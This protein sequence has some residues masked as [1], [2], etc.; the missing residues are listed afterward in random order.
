M[1]CFQ[2]LINPQ[3]VGYNTFNATTPCWH[4]TAGSID[5]TTNTTGNA[6]EPLYFKFPTLP[7]RPYHGLTLYNQPAARGEFWGSGMQDMYGSPFCP[8]A[9]NFGAYFFSS[10]GSIM[11]L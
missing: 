11:D 1:D 3:S 7:A 10:K 6:V 5:T 8:C 9:S 4:K 2:T